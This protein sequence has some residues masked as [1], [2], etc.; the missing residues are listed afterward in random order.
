M[1]GLTGYFDSA[2]A[3]STDVLVRMTDALAHRGPDAS[4][5][6]TWHPETGG[7]VGLGHRRLSIIDL[8]E[9]GAQPM[10]RGALHIVFNGEI[11]NYQEITRELQE[12]GHQFV[13]TSDTE[14]ILAAVDEWGIVDAINRFNG[15]FAFAI[16]DSRRNELVLVRDRTG[17]KPLYY[18]L[19]KN[20]VL[21]A[22]ELKAFHEHPAFDRNLNANA[23]D[24]FFRF[25]YVPNSECIFESARKL[26]PGHLLRIDLA[27]QRHVL[28]E[29][30]D[31]FDAFNQPKLKLDFVEASQQLEE[32]LVSAFN[33]RM[34]S[35]VPVGVFL[36]GGYDSSAVTALLQKS[37]VGR[38]KTFTIGF[39]DASF[40]EAPFAKQI[41]DAI[42][43]DHTEYTC[44]RQEAQAIIPTLAHFYDEPF[45]DSS[46]IPTILVSQIA[47]RSVKVALSADAG[48]E[49]FAGYN[50]YLRVIEFLRLA[51]KIPRPFRQG[52]FFALLS[53]LPLPRQMLKRTLENLSAVYD[54][55]LSHCGL[56]KL[57]SQV[58]RDGEINAMLACKATPRHTVFESEHLLVAE[59]DAVNRMLAIDYKTYL[60]DDILTKVDR[61]TMSCSL[62]GREPLLDFRIAEFA[63][64]LP[65]EFKLNGSQQ[66]L[67]LKSITH[68]HVPRG[69]LDRPK[70][71]F[72]V[73][74][75]QWLRGDLR[76]LVDDYLAPG[77]VASQGILN[78]HFTESFKK[79]FFAGDMKT[80]VGM[81]NLL[82]FQMWM[83]R[84]GKG[85]SVVKSDE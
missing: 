5:Q 35:D 51:Q 17:V 77:L 31:V 21:F 11:Y 84:W 55:R 36:S 62:E 82:M 46:A 12:L 57:T 42:G 4:G 83:E 72:S 71:G 20:L 33:Y 44:T 32:L 53:K 50:K 75:F 14:V 16:Y 38:L 49:L 60:P 54:E 3:T 6:C 69:L 23:I 24:S 26:L 28:E 10:T 22:S 85:C 76:H 13:S 70:K 45:G 74:Y 56:M 30:W 59:N 40:N 2:N 19:H 63:A 43:T 29:Y 37:M 68:R 81:W 41:A 78:T 66:K 1:C 61:A 73:P 8:S 15:M 65:S 67:I 34:V 18:S 7:T 39:E 79:R 52:R 64:R 9:G 58:F 80:N 48:D 25:G 47:R 27:T